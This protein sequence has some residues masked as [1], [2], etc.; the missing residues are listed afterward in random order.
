MCVCVWLGKFSVYFLHCIYWSIFWMSSRGSFSQP[1][2]PKSQKHY[3]RW[4]SIYDRWT[5]EYIIYAHAKTHCNLQHTHHQ[6]SDNLSANPNDFSSHE[7]DHIVHF[8][9]FAFNAKLSFIRNSTNEL[10]QTRI[11]SKFIKW[12]VNKKRAWPTNTDH[13]LINLAKFTDR[14]LIPVS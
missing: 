5:F 7:K 4:F 13:Y 8:L 3:N 6:S 1:A 14:F 10:M 12:R 2:W 11:N 9:S